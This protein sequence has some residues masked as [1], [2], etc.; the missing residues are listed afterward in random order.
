MK[1]LFNGR[2]ANFYIKI[3]V[4]LD[5]GIFKIPKSPGSW[6]PQNPKIHYVTLS[7]L[8]SSPMDLYLLG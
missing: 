2:C 8:I 6:D 1:L 3:F 4:F 5:P 7:P